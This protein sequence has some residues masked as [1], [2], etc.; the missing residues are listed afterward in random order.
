MVA[1]V[2]VVLQKLEIKFLKEIPNTNASQFFQFSKAEASGIAQKPQRIYH[3]G[4][5]GDNDDDVLSGAFP[6]EA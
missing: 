6:T 2:P 4:S 5:G 3:G 1:S